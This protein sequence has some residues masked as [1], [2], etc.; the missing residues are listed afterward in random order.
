LTR[1]V[2]LGEYCVPVASYISKFLLRRNKV[3]LKH[4]HT[5]MLFRK[6]KFERSQSDEFGFASRTCGTASVLGLLHAQKLL[7]VAIFVI[8]ILVLNTV[9]CK[10]R[11]HATRRKQYDQAFY[12]VQGDINLVRCSCI[13]IHTGKFRRV[14]LSL[15]VMYVPTSADADAAAG[16]QSR[17]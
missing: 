3:A 9:N 5:G 14:S 16:S 13:G 17:I 12:C 7:P 10:S 4:V 1:T 8:P 15:F 6:L 2:H 11:D